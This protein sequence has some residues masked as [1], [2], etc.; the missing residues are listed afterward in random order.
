MNSANTMKLCAVNIP[1]PT[2]WKILYGLI[3]ILLLTAPYSNECGPHSILALTVM[4]CH[5]LPS[6]NILLVYM[7]AN[8]AQ[9]SRWW[10]AKSIIYEC[11]KMDP[12]M[13][14]F[15]TN[16]A[17]PIFSKHRYAYPF[18]LATLL[19]QSTHS[20]VVF[21]SNPISHPYPSP[22]Q[23]TQHPTGSHG[24][25]LHPSKSCQH[26]NILQLSQNTMC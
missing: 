19:Q 23:S 3:V 8:I 6:E 12:I 17:Q 11:V 20:K 18:D 9:I 1:P 4:S 24:H 25:I 14:L 10:T 2:L 5:P 26:K 7:D 22:S 13:S 16:V 21:Q 15:H